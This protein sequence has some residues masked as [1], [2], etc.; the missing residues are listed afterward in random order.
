MILDAFGQPASGSIE[1]SIRQMMDR[2][3]EAMQRTIVEQMF[4]S[5]PRLLDQFG[6]NLLPPEGADGFLDALRDHKVHTWSGREL[7]VPLTYEK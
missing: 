2:A 7:S 5:S 6:N 3:A 4:K 1:S